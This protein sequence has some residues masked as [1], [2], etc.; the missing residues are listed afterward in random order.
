MGIEREME[1]P[2]SDQVKAAMRKQAGITVPQILIG[3]LIIAL[4]GA[5]IVSVLAPQVANVRMDNA[6]NEIYNINTAVQKMKAYKGNYEPLTSFAV[7]AQRGYVDR[8]TTGVSENYFD[9]TV[10][11][12]S[13]NEN[14]DATLTYELL[15]GE[16]CLN[17]VDRAEAFPGIVPGT[18]SCAGANNATFTMTVD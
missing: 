9:G 2:K 15:N 5:A 12:V 10:T 7:L 14:L 4:I 6:F 16:D 13:A 8:Y 1:M 11:V 18:A 3:L 17:M